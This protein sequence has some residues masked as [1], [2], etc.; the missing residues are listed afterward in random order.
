[1]KIFLSLTCFFCLAF[2]SLAQLD[3]AFTNLTSTEGTLVI[4]LH[5]SESSFLSNEATIKTTLSVDATEVRHTYDELKPGHYAIRVFHDLNSN[6]ELDK[7]FVGIPKEPYGVSN[8]AKERFGPP[9]YDRAR[10]Y[11][12]GTSMSL[13]ISVERH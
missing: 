10:F 7:N 5:D 6:D 1:M 11:Y 12:D 3:V 13:S 9:K 8:N 2:S 4:V